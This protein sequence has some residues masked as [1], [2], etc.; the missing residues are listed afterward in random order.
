MGTPFE[1]VDAATGKPLGKKVAYGEEYSSVHIPGP[2]RNRLTAVIAYSGAART[3][4]NSVATRVVLIDG[5]RLVALM[6]RY[7]VGVQVRRTVVI[8]EIDEGFFE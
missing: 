8:V 1:A 4:A 6:I 2:L 5:T 7:G 3:Y